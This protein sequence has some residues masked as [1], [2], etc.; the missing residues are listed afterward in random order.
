LPKKKKQKQSSSHSPPLIWSTSKG[1][2]VLFFSFVFFPFFVPF[3]L[4]VCSRDEEA[5]HALVDFFPVSCTTCG[6]RFPDE[7]TLQVHMKWHFRVKDKTDK[8]QQTVR[9]RVFFWVSYDFFLLL[10]EISKSRVVSET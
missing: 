7:S 3:F 2:H 5:I 6:Q 8:Q 4:L 1:I 10:L 9:Y